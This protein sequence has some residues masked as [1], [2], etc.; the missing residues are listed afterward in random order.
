MKQFLFIIIMVLNI[1]LTHGQ[2]DSSSYSFFVAGHVYGAPGVNNVGFHP[3]FKHKLA[4][5]QGRPEIS[6]G[7]LL[8]DIVSPYPIAQD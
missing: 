6:L 5:I 1:I 8:G 7:V 3:P 2:S 4:Y